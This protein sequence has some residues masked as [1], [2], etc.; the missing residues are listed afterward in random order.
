MVSWRS[1]FHYL[2]RMLLLLLVVLPPLGVWLDGKPL[3][4]YLEFPPLTRYVQHADFS[5]IGFAFFVAV[6][7]AMLAPFVLALVRTPPHPSRLTLHV[8]PWWGWV[9]VGVTVTAWAL[10][11][12]RIPWFA[13]LQHFTFSPLWLGYILIIN[14]LTHRRT[15]HCMMLDRPRY[16]LLLFPLSAVLWWFFEYLNRFV[17]NWYYIGIEAFGP[18]EYALYATPPFATV[19]PAV[20]G[21]AEYLE[22]FP[23]LQ[24]ALQRWRPLHASHPKL[25]GWGTLLVSAFGLAGLGIWPD[26]LYALLWVSPLLMITSLQAIHGQPTIFSALRAGDWR[27][28]YLPAIAALICGFFWEMWNFYSAA[29]WVYTV[30]YVHRFQMFEMPVV[31]FGGYLPFGLEC[32][33]IGG[34]LADALEN[35][36]TDQHPTR[37]ER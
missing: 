17:Q 22:T 24:R 21:T 31:G 37:G 30:P 18:L 9:G 13:A 26:V 10:A 7:L 27:P 11:W 34:L 2:L 29:K 3:G 36:E 23:R 35:N 6:D 8:F 4:Q 14:A 15:G 32:A 25:I 12:T 16:F 20:L 19:L 28:I 5:W 33:V 1:S